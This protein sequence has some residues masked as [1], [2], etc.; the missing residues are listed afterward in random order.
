[1]RMTALI[2]GDI[3]FQFKYGF[4]FLYLVFSV[5]YISLLSALPIAWKAQAAVL[6]IFTDPA[7]MGLFFMG[8]IVLFEKS[9]QVLNSIA[10]SPVKPIEY[11][12][13]KLV[14]IAVISTGVALLIGAGGGVIGNPLYFVPG[15][16]LGSCLFS[17]VG[18][19]V[20]ANIAS[21]NQFIVATIP[22]ELLINIPAFAWMFGWKPGILLLHPGVCII[23]LCDNGAHALPA[24]AILIVWTALITLAAERVVRNSLRSL[25]GVKL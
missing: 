1:M 10:I 16:F 5:L 24:L 4:Y 18:L 14:T 15:V 22:A 7:A 23:E 20:A 8:A 11:V 9:E 17:A 19:M 21:L 13:S 12:I 2:R 25:G 6:M 3:R